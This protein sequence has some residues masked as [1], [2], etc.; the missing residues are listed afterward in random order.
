MNTA[1]HD[2]PGR[3]ADTERRGVGGET[4]EPMAEAALG[5]IVAGRYRLERFIGQGGMGMVWGGLDLRTG[6]AVALKMLRGYAR[7]RPDL[8]RRLVREARASVAVRHP[9]VIPV[10]DVF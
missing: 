2:E 4:M 7:A 3:R 1:S 10:H 9:N 5:T 6:R 8:Q